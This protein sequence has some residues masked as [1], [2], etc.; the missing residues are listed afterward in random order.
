MA[1][2]IASR[3]LRDR[4]NASWT[5]RVCGCQEKGGEGMSVC[6]FFF[7]KILSTMAVAMPVAA[8]TLKTPKKTGYL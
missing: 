6:L 4:A 2:T 1:E 5:W 8:M 3:K 7:F